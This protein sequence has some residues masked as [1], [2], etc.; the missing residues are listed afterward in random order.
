[1]TEVGLQNKDMIAMLALPMAVIAC[2]ALMSL[3]PRLRDAAFFLLAGG[4]VVSDKA[5]I[6]IFSS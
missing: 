6:D 5:D 2:T 3:F 4:L 1:M